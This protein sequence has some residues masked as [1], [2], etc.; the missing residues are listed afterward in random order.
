[1]SVVKLKK[2]S[3]MTLSTGLEPLLSHTEKSCIA[4]YY[5]Q[6]FKYI[7]TMNTSFVSPRLQSFA[8]IL[9]DKTMDDNLMYIPNDDMQN[10]P[11][12]NVH[13]YYWLKS[14]NTASLKQLF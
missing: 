10:N 8:W 4:S 14:L 2:K 6:F 12:N 13:Y 11:V 7:K 9:R 3:S 5:R 1:M